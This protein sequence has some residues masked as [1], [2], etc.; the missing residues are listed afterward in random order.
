MMRWWQLLL[1]RCWLDDGGKKHLR[2]LKSVR[3]LTCAGD[4]NVHLSDDL[5]QFHKSEAIHALKKEKK[6]EGEKERES[7]IEREGGRE[8]EK[9]RKK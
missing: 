4:D 2:L 8:G 7:E 9:E 5:I 3:N 1:V 6:T